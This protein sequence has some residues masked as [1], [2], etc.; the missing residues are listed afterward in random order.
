MKEE[1]KDGKRAGLAGTICV[2][3]ILL[4]VLLLLTMLSPKVPE[5][6]EGILISFGNVEY[7]SGDV[8][9]QTP[10]ETIDA[11]ESDS[12]VEE[13]PPPEPV[14]PTNVQPNQTQEVEEAPSIKPKE[15]KPKPVETTPEIKPKEKP[16]EVKPKVDTRALYP[17]K[18][19]NNNS[20]N[21][22]SQGDTQQPGDAGSV[23]G[24]L[25][26]TNSVGSGLGDSG[27]K[28]SLAGRK[29][30]VAPKVDDTSQKTGVV[31]INITVDKNGNVTNATGPGRG[32]TT[33]DTG[34]VSKSKTAALL[35]KFNPSST[36]TIIQKGTITFTFIVK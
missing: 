11:E 23:D 18:K 12:E 35:T 7:G 30:V 10:T 1:N 17:G 25:N 29:M 32:S 28:W 33:S 36:G 21:S 34:L 6:E 27:I 26:S 4:I 3:A 8:Q 16:K 15:E 9:P 22:G 13:A 14:Q 19:D 5:E 24:S 20:S 31:V 2:H